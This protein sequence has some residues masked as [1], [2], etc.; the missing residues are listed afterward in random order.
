MGLNAWWGG[1]PA[2]RPTLPSACSRP[3][4]KSQFDQSIISIGSAEN[5]YLEL[6]KSVGFVPSMPNQIHT[7]ANI[8]SSETADLI[9]GLQHINFVQ[10]L[11]YFLFYFLGGYLLYSAMFAAVGSARS[12]ERRV[13]KE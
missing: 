13:G 2:P 7:Q 3:E 4:R 10:M 8:T 6:E 1:P 11:F 12:E 9:K 5:S